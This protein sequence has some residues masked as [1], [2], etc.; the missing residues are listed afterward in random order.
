[1]QQKLHIGYTN[2]HKNII[3]AL[4][5]S[6]QHSVEICG[7]EANNALRKSKNASSKNFLVPSLWIGFEAARKEKKHDYS[8]ILIYINEREDNV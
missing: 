8:R 4:C 6:A 3:V 1:M 5:G 2:K 7:G